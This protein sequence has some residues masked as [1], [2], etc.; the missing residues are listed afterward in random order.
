MEYILEE[1]RIRIVLNFGAIPFLSF[2]SN[3]NSFH[4]K[5]KCRID[6]PKHGRQLERF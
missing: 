3:C 6:I 2:Y 1:S 4:F 5:T